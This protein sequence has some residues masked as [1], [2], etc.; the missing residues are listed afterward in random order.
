MTAKVTI[1]LK[2][3]ILDPQGRIILQ[4]LENLGINKIDEVRMGKMIRL[5]FGD[6]SK[7]E[8]EKLADK[9]CSKLLANPT[10]EQYKIE[11]EEEKE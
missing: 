6:V 2:D 10:I 4:A 11:I 9:A 5:R 3:G 8:A 7:D 1:M